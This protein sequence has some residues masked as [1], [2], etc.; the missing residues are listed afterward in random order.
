TAK[1]GAAQQHANPRALLQPE[2]AGDDAIQFRNAGLEQLVARKGLENV[3]QSLAVMAVGGER[4]V[5]HHLRHLVAQHGDLAWIAAV[6]RG[7][8][9]A[10]ASFLADQPAL[11]IEVLDSD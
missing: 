7:S 5:R 10:Q 2:D 11:G 4:E 8:P 9:P 6:G 3:L 1:W